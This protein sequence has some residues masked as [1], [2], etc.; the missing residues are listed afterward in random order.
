MIQPAVVGDGMKEMRAEDSYVLGAGLVRQ[1]KIVPAIQVMIRGAKLSPPHPE[2]LQEL[3]RLHG[4]Q[5]DLSR[6]D[7]CRAAGKNPGL[8]GAGAL[9]AGVL[10]GEQGETAESAALLERR[11][12]DPRLASAR[13]PTKRKLLART[14]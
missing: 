13:T 8:G 9:I 11:W 2:L 14:G 12:P 5:G 1:E 3:S 7:A 10:H 4:H 6:A